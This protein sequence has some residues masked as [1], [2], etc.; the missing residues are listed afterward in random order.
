MITEPDKRT[1]P[2]PQV[3]LIL[4]SDTAQAAGRQLT[5]MLSAPA[6]AGIALCVRALKID[7]GTPMAAVSEFIQD[8]GDKVACDDRSTGHAVIVIGGEI[9]EPLVDTVYH[10]SAPQMAQVIVACIGGDEPQ[11]RRFQAAGSETTLPLLQL[12]ERFATH[13]ITLLARQII[14]QLDV[15]CDAL[16]DKAIPLAMYPA[17]PPRRGGSPALNADNLSD[18]LLRLLPDWSVVSAASDNQA[19][20][21][22]TR[23]Y[24]FRSFR[25]A[26]R[27]MDQTAPACDI[28]DHHP[29]WENNWRTLQVWLTTWDADRQITERDI[30]LARYF[31]TVYASIAE[32]FQA[33]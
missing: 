25:Q 15:P 12:R 11:P 3:S 19:P 5:D 7:T 31:D 24:N 22:I 30:Q 8:A 17:V 23:Q 10:A 28:A 18:T 2:T 16:T 4:T 21:D 13:D 14:A 32:Q 33:N 9:S 29:R 20:M 27:F 6:L 1:Q 26:V